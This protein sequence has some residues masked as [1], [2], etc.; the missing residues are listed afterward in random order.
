MALNVE[1]FSPI[2]NFCLR[3]PHADGVLGLK[4]TWVVYRTESHT[5]ARFRTRFGAVALTIRD[6]DMCWHIV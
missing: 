6:G 2:V 1:A 5:M 4:M 3:F